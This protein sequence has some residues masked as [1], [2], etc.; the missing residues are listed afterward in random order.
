MHPVVL[1]TLCSM[2]GAVTW[3]IWGYGWS[4]ELA[5]L[6]VVLVVFCI[7]L[8]VLL[9]ALILVPRSQWPEFAKLCRRT[10]IQDFADL[11]ATLFGPR[12][13]RR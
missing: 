10:F 11:K 9:G 8:V 7:M 13:G 3:L 1:L 4:F 5:G 6:I 2:T 12:D